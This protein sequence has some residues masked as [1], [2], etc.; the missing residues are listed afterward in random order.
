MS[1]TKYRMP[2]DV[3]G[4]CIAL[5]KGYKRRVTLYHERRDNVLLATPCQ[6]ETYF[7][8][9]DGKKVELRSYK[10]RSIN[11]ISRPVEDKH[12]KLLEIENHPDTLLMR[13]VEQS[14]VTIGVDLENESDAMMLKDAIV[15]SCLKGRD[16]TFGHWALPM[17]KDNFYERRR[18]FLWYIAKNMGFL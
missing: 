14:M 12:S 2:D 8:K 9:V 5:V 4:L 3:K 6:Y 16:F 15:S 13:A 18:Q 10:Q 7:D 17:G 11:S 1:Q